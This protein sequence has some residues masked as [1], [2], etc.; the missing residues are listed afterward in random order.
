MTQKEAIKEIGAWLENQD[1]DE[2]PFSLERFRSIFRNAGVEE[3][4][5]V[6]SIDQMIQETGFGEKSRRFLKEAKPLAERAIRDASDQ[7]DLNL[8]QIDLFITVSCTG[9]TIPSLDAHLM[10]ELNFGS[11]TRRLPIAE[12]GCAG[13][14]S[15]LARAYDYLK[16]YPD[17][18]V[19]LLS[20]E[21]CTINSQPA[22]LTRAQIIAGALFGDGAAAVI[23]SGEQN[24]KAP[25]PHLA[26][27]D[28]RFL[29]DTLNHMGYKNNEHG[30][31]IMLSPKLPAEVKRS[32]GGIIETFLS[33]HD[34]VPG[35]IDHF[36]AH[37][38]GRAILDALE[39]TLDHGALDLRESRKILRNF[40][41]LS[42]AT[43]LFVLDEI[44]SNKPSLGDTGLFLAFGPGFNTDLGLLK[45]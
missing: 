1:T 45:W 22:D 4:R 28:S 35:D 7:A 15:G 26:G 14:A 40:G 23:L 21:L 5:T 44:L 27:Y 32:G 33:E 13:G 9:F 29:Q 42:S 3:R 2:L 6:S 25:K 12:L 24:R 19:L 31:S 36:V 16:A 18:T 38:G 37:P 39:E 20:T 30:M 43:I 8:D 11:D 34:L 10:N 17:A 41:N